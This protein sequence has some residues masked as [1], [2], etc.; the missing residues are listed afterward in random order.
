M[1]N[2]KKIE[3]QLKVVK[4]IID[5]IRK[6]EIKPFEMLEILD[7]LKLSIEMSLVDFL[8]KHKDK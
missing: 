5:L 8:I 2:K 7:N 6:N 1:E 3:K 4:E